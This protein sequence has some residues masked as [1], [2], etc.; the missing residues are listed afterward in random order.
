VS[1]PVI[2]LIA[3]VAK[4]GVIGAGGAL[5]WRLSSDL[6]HFK[7]ATMGKPLIMGRKTY[8][9]IGA[10]LA[11]RTT[12][13]VTRDRDFAAE[14]ILVAPGVDEALALA[15][16]AARAGGS[17][18]ILVAGG[19]EVYAET[20]GRAARLLVTEVDLAPAGDAHFPA[21]DPAL[22]RE[23]RRVFGVRGPRDDADFAFVEYERRSL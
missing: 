12:I 13:V 15:E 9:S 8:Q 16:A 22:W 2:A 11:G 20:I 19:G 14:G 10:P 4:N 18:E 21:I 5:P 23:A 17:D 7:A 6:K 3:A 1:G